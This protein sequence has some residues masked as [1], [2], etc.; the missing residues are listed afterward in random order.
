VHNDATITLTVSQLSR[1]LNLVPCTLHTAIHCC[2]VD[3]QHAPLACVCGLTTWIPWQ[4][5]ASCA[6]V[7][8]TLC[9][10]ALHCRV[11]LVISCLQPDHLDA[12][13][14]GT[15]LH[16]LS[17]CVYQT[18]LG[19]SSRVQLN[20]LLALTNLRSLEMAYRGEL[21]PR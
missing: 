18:G 6:S 13:A 5:A 9:I 14:T 17:L 19:G 20:P 3:V 8:V 1:C 21:S 10:A 16:S 15:Q 2:Q 4:Q 11:P 12:L 7:C